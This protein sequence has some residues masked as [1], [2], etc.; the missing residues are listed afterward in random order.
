VLVEEDLE[1]DNEQST[2]AD[3]RIEFDIKAH[4]SQ[5]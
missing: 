1:N 3:T 4:R 5:S 2:L